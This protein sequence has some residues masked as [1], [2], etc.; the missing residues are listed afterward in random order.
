MAAGIELKPRSAGIP[1]RS[2]NKGQRFPSR[3]RRLLEVIL[4]SVLPLRF[5]RCHACNVRRVGLNMKPRAI[6]ESA[7]IL[8]FVFLVTYATLVLTGVIR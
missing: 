5:Y 8:V 1:C 3:P 6:L 2:C 7:G 4:A